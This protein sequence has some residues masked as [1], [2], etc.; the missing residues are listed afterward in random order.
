[1]PWPGGCCWAVFEPFLHSQAPSGHLPPSRPACTVAGKGRPPHSKGCWREGA[2]AT[3]PGRVRTGGEAKR[4]RARPSALTPETLASPR[5]P[6][7]LDHPVDPILA[8]PAGSRL[9]RSKHLATRHGNYSA[10]RICNFTS[11][12]LAS[13]ARSNAFIESSKAKVSEISGFRSTLPEAIRA[14]ARSY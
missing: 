12:G 2:V 7:G 10:T 5:G 6:P 11:P 9:C 8:R 3:P 4:C 1:M 13:T 14:M